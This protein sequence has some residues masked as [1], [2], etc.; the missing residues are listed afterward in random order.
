MQE[1]LDAT[2]HPRCEN[3]LTTLTPPRCEVE[4]L[5]L[6]HTATADQDMQIKTCAGHQTVDGVV[7]ADKVGDVLKG[8]EAG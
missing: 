6:V 1:H 3:T 7:E 5:D 8:C 2:I 4:R